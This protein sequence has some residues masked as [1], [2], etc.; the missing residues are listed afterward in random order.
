MQRMRF[1]DK[2]Y[3][4][5]RGRSAK[6]SR[7]SYDTSDFY[8]LNKVTPGLP[9]PSGDVSFSSKFLILKLNF[10]RDDPLIG[11]TNI[12]KRQ[13]DKVAKRLTKVGQE[14]KATID[15]QRVLI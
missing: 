6:P 11:G 13:F 10:A 12:G 15:M 9:G 1:P 4:R 7:D 5:E 3:D 8:S 2:D 14:K